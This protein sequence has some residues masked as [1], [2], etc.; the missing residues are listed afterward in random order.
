VPFLR[1]EIRV[2]ASLG[3]EGV[4]RAI[5]SS[6]S[7]HA[8][9]RQGPTPIFCAL[10]AVGIT[11]VQTYVSAAAKTL[12]TTPLV[13]GK[14][15]QEPGVSVQIEQYLLCSAAKLTSCSFPAAAASRLTSCC[16]TSAY[17]AAGAS[18]LLKPASKTTPRSY[19]RR[20]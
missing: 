16:R 4:M 20:H 17:F 10:T 3:C 15:P 5:A 18:Q 13:K 14:S 19:G 1:G 11:T 8:T 9:P 6:M 2:I 12:P 7:P